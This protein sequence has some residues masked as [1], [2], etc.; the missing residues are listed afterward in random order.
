MLLGVDVLV[1][2][3]VERD[4]NRAGRRVEAGARRDVPRAQRVA[5]DAFIN[6]VE[7]HEIVECD[8]PVERGPRQRQR[9]ALADWLRVAAA[10]LHAA[11]A[12]FLGRQPAL[13][14]VGD[15]AHGLARA[16]SGV[17]R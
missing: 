11:G 10:D 12:R 15:P 17:R 2:V 3:R 4:Q 8:R 16:A 13:R 1:L 14:V 6:V 5:D 7:H 9:L